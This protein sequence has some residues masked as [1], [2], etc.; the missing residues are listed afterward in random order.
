MK[1]EDEI[2][3]L[4]SDLF[5]IELTKGK[6]IL[7]GKGLI[8]LNSE[9]L[10]ELKVFPD[11]L[12]DYGIT[13]FMQE[14]NENNEKVGKL[15][16]EDSYYKLKAQSVNGDLFFCHRVYLR[17]HFNFKVYTCEICAELIITNNLDF[18]NSKVARIEIPYTIK[19]PY[20]HALQSEK[21]YS[22]KWTSAS[23]SLEIFEIQVE[24]LTIDI[25]S[26]KN[27][28]IILV[29]GEDQIL[30]KDIQSIITTIEFL[31]AS[32]I[33]RYVIEFEYQGQFKKIFHFYFEQRTEILNGYPPLR[34]S[35]T[36]DRGSYTEMF[37]KFF[38]FI[39]LNNGI[40]IERTFRRIIS[41]RNSF[42]INYAQT[43]TT[44]VEKLLKEYFSNNS[45]KLNKS[46]IELIV[47]EIEKTTVCEK[48]KRRLK[49]MIWNIFGQERS[50]NILLDLV[51]KSK[52]DRNFYDIWKTLRNSVNHGEDPS[53]D[54]NV[55]HNYCSTNLVLYYKLIF[56]LIDYK[57]SYSDYSTI[58]Y[59]LRKM[60]L[61][62]ES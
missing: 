24:N 52:I 9:G 53:Q 27:M 41:S 30:V 54:L 29:Q 60:Q 20:N 44:A 34:I 43:L 1:L 32:I 61:T 47:A 55:Y 12:K 8:Y 10:V 33:D 25:F 48:I 31:T 36:I 2:T 59:P 26:K 4:P 13:D 39:K 57:G 16:P 35:I 23:T 50:D 28:T 40:T 6:E 21:K 56:L 15:I 42:I 46:E 62:E 58:G 51:E 3:G 45:L 49:G 7:I 5:S 19:L 38:T 37:L 18:T 17:D 14:L 22:D 11:D